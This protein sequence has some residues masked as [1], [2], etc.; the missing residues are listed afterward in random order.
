MWVL[1]TACQ[2]CPTGPN[3]PY[4]SSK[5]MT[6]NSTNTPA[7]SIK[8]ADGA[9]IT[10]KLATDSVSIAGY[11]TSPDY[12]F[13]ETVSYTTMDAITS[14]GFDGTLGFMFQST[15]QLETFPRALFSF[16]SS[17]PKRFSTCIYAD[18]LEGEM[19]MGGV[20]IARLTTPVVTLPV[21]SSPSRSGGPSV[22]NFW[23]TTM[24][25]FSHS[26]LSS[27]ITSS[28]T[29]AFDTGTSLMYIPADLAR[30][31]LEPLGLTTTDVCSCFIFMIRP[32]AI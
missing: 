7:Q 3:A 4:N 22:F 21:E 27:N 25:G 17:I 13:I 32:L 20:N 14:S 15:R 30:Q 2:T 28:V 26:Y 23:K 31:L 29:V 8:Y 1:S 6:G 24:T 11:Q 10:G 18:E 16:N 9:G 19:I 12:R 5:S